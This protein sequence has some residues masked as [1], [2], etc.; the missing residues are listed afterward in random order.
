LHGQ[1]DYVLLKDLP[2]GLNRTAEAL[3][4]F[5]Y[6]PLE[7]EP[8][9]MLALSPQWRSFDD[10]LVHLNKKYRKAALDVF[11]TLDA[12]GV[13]VRPLRDLDERVE[14]MHELYHAVAARAQVRLAEL[15]AGYF[16]VLARSLGD[17]RFVVLGAEQADRLIAFVSVIRDGQTAVGYYLGLD[18]A[19]NAEL[20]VYH[21]MLYAVIEQSIRWGCSQVS[22]GRT[23]LEAKARLGCQPVPTF[24]WVRHRVP[25]LNLVVRQ[26]LKFVPHDAPP[27]RNPFRGK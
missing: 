22:F 9:M 1:I 24:V 20:P 23:A 11:G 16:A 14:R 19:A 5:S 7:T 4:R 18:Y 27:V 6:R 8:E 17:E 25:L 21:R 13:V 3:G 12:A 2:D 26:L 15:P 10:Y